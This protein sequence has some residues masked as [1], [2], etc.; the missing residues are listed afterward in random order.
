MIL[1]KD[2]FMLVTATDRTQALYHGTVNKTVSGR[3]CQRWDSQ[4]PHRHI[5]G[6]AKNFP[7]E[8]LA[9]AAN[10]CRDPGTYKKPWCYTTDPLI[11]WEECDVKP[12]EFMGTPCQA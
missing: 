10:Y 4:Q 12:C 6:D 5:N 7:T 2:C 8:S 1:A 11:R 3:T 9:E